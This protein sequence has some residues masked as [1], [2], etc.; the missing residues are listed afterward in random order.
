MLELVNKTLYQRPIESQYIAL[1]YGVYAVKEHKITLANSGLPYPL[2]VH[3]GEPKFLD[4][5]GIPLGLFPESQYQEN[6]IFLE[7]G[8][9]LVFYS[10]GVVEMRNEAGEDFGLRRLAEVVRINARNSAQE[11]VNAVD[12]SVDAFAGRAAASD[13]RTMIVMKMDSIFPKP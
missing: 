5:A 1:V 9:V 6:E 13:D 7:S 3:N 11:I 10:D 2:L 8:D 4:L 12:E